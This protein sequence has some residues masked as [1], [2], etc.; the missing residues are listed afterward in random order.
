VKS[1]CTNSDTRQSISKD[2]KNTFQQVDVFGSL[3]HL[4]VNRDLLVELDDIQNVIPATKEHGA[5]FVNVGGNYVQDTF[6]AR[7][8][9]SSSLT[10]YQI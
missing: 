5:S 3:I 6:C 2:R 1:T 4:R 7:R 10:R 9:D 8:R